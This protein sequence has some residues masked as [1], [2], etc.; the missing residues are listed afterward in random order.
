MEIEEIFW[1][2]IVR[3][4]HLVL[5]PFDQEDPRHSISLIFIA[6]LSAL[7]QS[8]L[9]SQIGSESGFGEDFSRGVFDFEGGCL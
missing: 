5:E 9:D 7:R 1:N 6:N 8:A 2:I 4:L 3:M